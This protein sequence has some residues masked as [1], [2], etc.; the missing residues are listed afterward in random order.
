MKKLQIE[1]LES[2]NQT[3]TNQYGKFIIYPLNKGQALT[4]GNAL[5]RIMLA[6]LEGV[7]IS[8]VR[9]AGINHEF[10]TVEGVREDVLDILLNLKQ[11]IFKSDLDEPQFIRLKVSGPCI[12]TASDLELPPRVEL[13]DPRQY[14]STIDKNSN[15]EMEMKI[16]KGKGYDLVSKKT[17]EN[18]TE[19]LKVD[20]VYMPI[21]KVMFHVKEQYTGDSLL[22]EKLILQITTNGSITPK[23]AIIKAAELFIKML[24]PLKEITMEAEEDNKDNNQE[25][26]KLHQVPI[27]ELHLSVRAYNCLKRAQIFSVAD[28]LDYSEEDLLEIKNFGYKSAEEVMQAL[29]NYLGITLPKTKNKS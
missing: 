3:P 4:L 6:D 15:L 9:I 2:F 7:A 27:E 29:Q 17:G 18:L 23:E 12:V 19:S 20:A 21:R 11:I 16:E 26:K 10:T 1:C 13:V 14:I 24:E 8:S 28:L 5:R 25:E 22:C